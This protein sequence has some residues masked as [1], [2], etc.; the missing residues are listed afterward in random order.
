[1]RLVCCT[2][3]IALLSLASWAQGQE[4]P[5]TGGKVD[6][7]YAKRQAATLPVQAPEELIPVRALVP[8]DLNPTAAVSETPLQP[9]PEGGQI[10]AQYYNGETYGGYPDGVVPGELGGDMGWDYGAM[11]CPPEGG[12][13]FGPNWMSIIDPTRAWFGVDYLSWWTKGDQLPPLV[14]TSPPGTSQSDIGVLGEPGTEVLFGD[15]RVV[16]GQRTGGRIF[17]GWWLGCQQ[18]I[19]IQG[20]YYRFE[21]E[22]EQFNADSRFVNPGSPDPFLARPFFNVEL[23]IQDSLVLA[24]PN[25][26]FGGV[27]INLSGTVDVNYT[28]DIQSGG[29]DVRRMLWV[30]LGC[31]YRLSCIGGYRYFGV[32]EDLTI[33]TTTSPTG[34]VFPP[35]TVF[36]VFDQFTTRNEFHGGEF[37]FMFEIRRGLLTVET[38]SKV[39]LG[40]MHEVLDI[41]G[42]ASIFNGAVTVFGD[43]GF[44]AAGTNIG[45]YARDQFA[46]IPEVGVKG[47]VQILPRLRANFGYEFTYVSR[48]A[49]PGQQIDLQINPTQDPGPIVGDAR[50]R[51]LIA[52][53]SMILQGFNAGFELRF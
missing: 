46:V 36:S 47:S 48:L 16:D 1:M 20:Y 10:P 14:T 25:F 28:S 4:T 35:G 19:G 3:G 6:P 13:D 50:P 42:A 32:D 11:A 7:Y 21:T 34:N 15:Q 45:R 33:F 41:N 51:A 38:T 8:E 43:Q 49:R 39:A 2:A 31:N 18:Q 17:G 22:S 9:T 29:L 53:S 37:G 5:A 27:P 24:F 44:L 12:G 52:G 26:I 30:D 40:N 23:G